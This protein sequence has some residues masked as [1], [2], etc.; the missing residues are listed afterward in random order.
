MRLR[1]RGRIR[2]VLFDLDDTLFD[3]R[4]ARRAALR[5][6]REEEP[7]LGRIPLTTLDQRNQTILER[8]HRARVLTGALTID[9]ARA[10]RMEELFRSFGAPLTA[11]E[12]ARAARVYS[13]A[14][15][16]H[17]RAVPGARTLLRRLHGQ[18]GL[19]VVSNNLRAA[20]KEKLRV[21]G[22]EPWLDFLVCSEQVGVPKPFPEIFRVALVAAGAKARQSVMVGDSWEVDVLGARAAGLRPVWFNREGR[23]VEKGLRV[24]QLQSFLPVAHA[25]QVLLLGSD[26]ALVR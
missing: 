8:L 16:A 22:L 23:S 9:A 21:C 2:A 26:P 11:A 10:A 4:R 7:A 12:A 24:P 13:R 1:S 25:V 15:R 14:Y 3:H 17:R 20:Q 6:L 5:A 18:V 19:G